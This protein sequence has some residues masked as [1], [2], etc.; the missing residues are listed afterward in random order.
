MNEDKHWCPVY[1]WLIEITIT[2]WYLMMMMMM[3]MMMI[4]IVQFLM[5]IL[6]YIYTNMYIYIY[7]FNQVCD[8]TKC[9]NDDGF[10]PLI[11]QLF[12]HPLKICSNINIYIITDWWFGT[13]ILFF[14]ILGRIIPTDFHIFQR[15]WNHQP[16]IIID[17]Y[18]QYTN[19]VYQ[20][21]HYIHIIL[22][23]Y[24]YI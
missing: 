14:H 11:I 20:W 18:V 13:L 1:R 24:I 21:Y 10:Y 3:I 22:Y 15:G 2:M 9:W 8:N 5:M 7:L 17:I 12:T 23:W 16:D 19:G 6:I 4:M